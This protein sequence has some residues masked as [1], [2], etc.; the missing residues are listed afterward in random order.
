MNE[1]LKFLL[2]RLTDGELRRMEKRVYNKMNEGAG[3]QPYGMDSLTM[4]I[5]KPVEY[6]VLL[7]VREEMRDR[8][9]L[10]LAELR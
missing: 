8:A 6:A 9:K 1:E 10:K 7:A 3:Y 2:G 4:T 5:V